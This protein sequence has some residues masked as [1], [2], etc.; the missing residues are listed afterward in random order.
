VCLSHRRA[1]HGCRKGKSIARDPEPE[2]SHVLEVALASGETKDAAV[3]PDLAGLEVA[4]GGNWSFKGEYLYMEFDSNNYT[5]ALI[6]DDGALPG[7]TI[8]NVDP[9]NAHRENWS[10]LSV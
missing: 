3:P 2:G 6:T 10:E 9:R 5:T 8:A 4:L 1:S 7:T